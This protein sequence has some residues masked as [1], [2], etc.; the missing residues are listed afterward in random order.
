MSFASRFSMKT[1]SRNGALLRRLNGWSVPI[2][3]FIGAISNS[4]SEYGFTSRLPFVT[5]F[6]VYKTLDF[7]NLTPHTRPH[8]TYN[9]G[10]V[11]EPLLLWSGSL[12]SNIN[13]RHRR[14]APCTYVVCVHCT[15]PTG[16]YTPMPHTCLASSAEHLGLSSVLS[17]PLLEL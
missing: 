16:L 3:K 9:S 13:I 6:C 17:R 8:M 12:C 11:G 1:K 10:H 5:R 14:F 2:K 7:Q 4:L 15:S